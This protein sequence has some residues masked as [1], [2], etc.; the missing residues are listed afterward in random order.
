MSPHLDIALPDVKVNF[1][2]QA[3]EFTYMRTYSRWLSD[4]GRRETWEETVERYLQFIYRHVGDRVPTRVFKHI[5]KA[6]LLF[7]VVPSMRALWSAGPASEFDNLCM[8]NC[9][10]QAADKTSIFGECLYIL[11]CGC[12]YG[13]SVEQDYVEKLPEIKPFKQNVNPGRFVIEDS[14]AGWA[15]SQ[16]ALIEALYDGYDLDFDYSQLR[17]R[18]SRLATMGGRSSGPEPLVCLHNY[19]RGV[20]QEAQG[21]KLLPIEIH[22][23]LNE[24]GEI[25]IVG[26]V[27]R[28]A[29]MSLSS[30]DDQAMAEAK[31]WPFP[32]RRR[33]ANNSA[34]YNYK[35]SSVEFLKEWSILASSGTGE[36]GIFNRYSTQ[37]RAPRRRNSDL[38]IGTN[39]CGEINL[40]SEQLCNL[41]EIILRH[42]DDLDMV[43]KKLETATWIGAIQSTFTNFQYLNKNWQKNCEEERL[44]GVSITGQMD[45]I[46]LLNSDALREM[47]RKVVKVARHAAKK[48]GINM[49]AAT[50][51]VKPSGTTSQVTN[52][53]SGLHP[54]YAQ[55]QIR[56]FRISSTDPL[57]RMLMDQ[58]VP[59]QPENGESK[60]DWA[61]AKKSENKKDVCPIYVEGEQWSPDRVQ[62]WVVS[63][64]VCSDNGSV[65]RHEMSAI[66]QLEHYKKLQ[67]NWCEHNASCF[68]GNTRFIT[69]HGL[70]HFNEFVHNENVMVL[71]SDGDFTP[72]IVKKFG[73]QQIYK[74]KLKSGKKEL[75]INTTADHLWPVTDA[76]QRYRGRKDKSYKT[77]DLPIGKQLNTVTPKFNGQYDLEGFLHGVV[78]GDGSYHKSTHTDKKCQ[79]YL[80]GDSRCLATYFK[81]FGSK[82]KER[83]DINQ[84]RI[85]GLPNHWKQL[86]DTNDPEYLRSFISG[87]F[88]ADGHISQDARTCTLTCGNHKV[89]EWLQ[90]VAPVAKLMV[91]TSIIKN[92]YSSK[93]FSK[94]EHF[95]TISFIK[96]SLDNGFFKH[97]KKL[98]RFK[99]NPI[100]QS[101]K[102]WRIVE[103]V[104]TN[105]FEDVYCVIEPKKHLFTLEGNILTHNCTVYVKE[106]EWFEVGH[107]VL[108]NWDIVS[109]VA[110]LPFDGG[111]YKQAPNEEVTK[112]EY[113]KLVSEMPK[114]DYSQLTKYE[115]NDNT[116]GSRSYACTGDKCMLT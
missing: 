113:E 60:E 22:D 31:E 47:K 88:A 44:L 109:G 112:K 4:E 111:K 103:V 71:G 110:F 34:V 106:D 37:R 52:S 2:N 81:E 105:R 14:R 53:S 33:M 51:C 24:T 73:K 90:E 77:V 86:P 82:P 63:F 58:D 68:T 8:Y 26:G 9:A 59:M 13:F 64:P 23:I 65:T 100:K 50:T 12:G 108:E 75:E 95:Y 5:K 61:K 39:P 3:A 41:S 62:T 87:W 102:R 49:P 91:S 80:C 93:S 54:R 36:R 55:Y 101:H 17:P 85:Y 19:T 70:K 115:K 67:E 107:W 29:E 7:G 92:K 89:L 35:P 66:K 76:Q 46:D 28:S 98:A 74:I 42:D 114:I 10:F 45:N 97:P 21:R 116:I 99:N 69:N 40:R 94:N 83:D 48:L 15:A 96:E 38:I 20:F 104:P 57:C 72:A 1:A 27:R 25:V 78:Y 16:N 32:L 84:T 79:I 30:L 18:G 6:M 43:F 56:R 11:M